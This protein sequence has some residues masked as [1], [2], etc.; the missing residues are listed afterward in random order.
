MKKILFLMSLFFG[1]TFLGNQTVL[2][3]D[4]PVI[5]QAI[6][7]NDDQPEITVMLADEHFKPIGKTYTLNKDNYWIQKDM[8]PI[9]KYKILPHVAE[10]QGVN[11]DRFKYDESTLEVVANPSETKEKDERPRFNMIL[12]GIDYVKKYSSM[13]YYPSPSGTKIYGV[14]SAE[15]MERYYKESVNRQVAGTTIRKNKQDFTPS[16]KNDVAGPEQAGKAIDMT[17]EAHHHEHEEGDG[18]HHDHDDLSNEEI[19]AKVEEAYK[20]RAKFK[21]KEEGSS[22]PKWIF[23]VGGL[24]IV[25]SG[26]AFW[27]FKIR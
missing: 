20:N 13:I 21:T 6:V 22:V 15:E 12:G 4:G 16:S 7:E 5:I 27:Y 19:K 11:L 8:V 24:F 1:M 2:A 17:E 9:G 26:I 18:H 23:I 25:I 14:N 10:L 3:E